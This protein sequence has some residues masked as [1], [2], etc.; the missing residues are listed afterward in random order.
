MNAWLSL[1]KK[2]LR[3]GFTA[4][5]VPIIAFVVVA[6]IATFFG[7][8]AGY[9]WEVLAVVSVGATGAQIAYLT[10]YLLWSLQSERKKLHLW[11]HNPLPAYALLLAKIVAG[12]ISM[13]VT[14]I[15]T[16]SVFFTAANLSED[17]SNGIPWSVIYD[18]AWIIG[19]HFFVFA[20]DLAIWFMF[21]W[22][23]YL[24]FTRYIAPFLS[25]V[26]IIIVAIVTSSLYGWFTESW[27]YQKLTMWG[28][29]N[30][31]EFIKFPQ[32]KAD[33]G[34]E[35]GEFTSEMS[36]M[37]AYVGEYVFGIAIALILFSIAAWMLDR[38]VEV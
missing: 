14:T 2:E 5:L 10:Y 18:N 24:I 1:T 27:L 16:L 30:V 13:A 25:S 23:I 36:N 33:I 28:E 26:L 31:S 7:Y 6:A 3:L 38:K 15:F 32:F 19:L 20:L 8:R 34:P 12:L 21:Y 22:M 9:T 29:I 37:S 11:L 35:G 17:F 4:F